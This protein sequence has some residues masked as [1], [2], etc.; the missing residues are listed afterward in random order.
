MAKW[1]NV[2][3][4]ELVWPFSGLELGF[5]SLK[6]VVVGHCLVGFEFEL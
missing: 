6:F 4:I 5:K 2:L 3:E 1:E